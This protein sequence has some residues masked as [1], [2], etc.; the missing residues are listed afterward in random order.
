M[1]IMHLSTTPLVGAPGSI[2]RALN[3][4]EGVEA[5]WAVLDATVGSYD[6]M[7]FDLDLQWK[8]DRQQIIDLVQRCDVLHLHNFIGLDSKIFSPIDF[9]VMWN[10]RRTI[11][12]HF[13]STPMWVAK[14][15]GVSE[16]AILNCP[17][18]KLVIAQHQERFIGNARMVPNIVFPNSKICRLRSNDAPLRIGYA[19]SRFLSARAA[20]W[21]TKGYPE[22][23]KM[24]QRLVRTA[25]KQGL[26]IEID[27]IELVSHSECLRR[28]SDCDIFI[29]E[30]VTGSYHLNTLEA[31]CTGIA[32]LTFLDRRTQQ[33]ITALTGR[34]DFPAI[35][36][37]LEHAHD[38]LL[39]L[40]RDRESVRQI[41]LHSKEWMASHW[42]PFDFAEHF[43]D[44]YDQVRS[45]PHKSFPCRFGGNL[46]LQV[47]TVKLH[48]QL[49]RSRA[50]QWPRLAPPWFTGIKSAV[51]QVVRNCGLRK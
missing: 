41:G 9:R 47:A 2:C 10:Q 8:N 43:L 28:K 30:L 22:T 42:D 13:H 29:D 4:H 15:M 27:L 14:N 17:I 12:R 18:P 6:K 37:G 50:K 39:E 35:S 25:R 24:L 44:A 40:C 26:G 48:D 45:E 23:V 38:V 33:A 1:L 21:D 5:R 3:M 46:A 36:V 19:P 49:W 31:L 11:V 20:R 51:G 34:T 16:E 7:V 32:C